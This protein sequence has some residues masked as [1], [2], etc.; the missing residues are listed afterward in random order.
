MYTYTCTYTIAYTHSQAQIRIAK[1]F[2]KNI[3]GTKYVARHF[4]PSNMTC[5][6]EAQ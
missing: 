3:M 6:Y 2:K 4:K 5:K 1:L